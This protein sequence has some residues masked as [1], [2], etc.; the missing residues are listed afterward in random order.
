MIILIQLLAVMLGALYKRGLRGA[1]SLS[2]TNELSTDASPPLSLI[3][4]PGRTD[5]PT[6]PVSKETSGCCN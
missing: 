1:A 6:Q 5:R 3:L 2:Q 4:P